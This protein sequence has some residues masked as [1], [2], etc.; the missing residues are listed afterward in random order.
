MKAYT[1]KKTVLVHDSPPHPAEEY[2]TEVY[3]I[4]KGVVEV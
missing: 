3:L 1:A 4:S 2:P